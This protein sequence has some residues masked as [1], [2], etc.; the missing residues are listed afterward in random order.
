MDHPCPTSARRQTNLQTVRGAYRDNPAIEEKKKLDKIPAQVNKIYRLYRQHVIM[1]NDA[2]KMNTSLN[3]LPV[4]ILLLRQL[5]SR[6]MYDEMKQALGPY[7]KKTAPL[8]FATGEIIQDRTQQM[9]R[10]VEQ[11]YSELSPR[12]NMVSLEALN[13]IDCLP[14]LEDLESEPTRVELKEALGYLHLEKCAARM[15]ILCL[16]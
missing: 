15:V 10:W 1:C 9:E 4:F 5:L 7:Q 11:D 16:W 8:N 2:V 3:S 6:H 14:V 13:A 12:E